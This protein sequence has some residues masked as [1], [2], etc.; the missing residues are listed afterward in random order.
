MPKAILVIGTLDSKGMECAFLRAALKEVGRA[1]VALM[2]VGIMG[3]ATVKADITRE[4]VAEAAGSTLATLMALG[5]RQIALR[6]MGEG[7]AALVQDLFAKGHLAGVV[8]I[9]GSGGTDLAAR[10]MSVLP[11]GFPRLIISTIANM[12]MRPYI[13]FRDIALLQSAAD[14]VGLNGVSRHTLRLGAAAIVGMARSVETTAIASADTRSVVAITALGLTTP[15]AKSAQAFL[16]NAGFEVV[17]FHATGMGGDAMESLISEGKI[18]GVLDLTLVELS[19]ATFGGAGPAKSPRPNLRTGLGVPRV[20]V[21][22]GLDMIKFGPRSAVP[23]AFRAQNIHSHSDAVSL[24]RV[25]IEQ[26][27]ELG[28]TLLERIS[29]ATDPVRVLLPLKGLSEI[30]RAGSEFSNQDAN[31]ALFAALK[32]AQTKGADVDEIDAHINDPFFAETAAA[33]L[34]AMLRTNSR[35]DVKA[36]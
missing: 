14:L 13:G 6:T 8:A 33:K 17:V 29:Q 23:A 15:A 36:L 27:V 12:D 10:A 24:V 3:A 11:M 9:G 4:R 5:N 35:R 28:R 26:A 25:N 34:A 7:A 16:E 30:D 32:V 18:Q 22:G 21:P 31:D 2:D 19:D 20:L 1:H